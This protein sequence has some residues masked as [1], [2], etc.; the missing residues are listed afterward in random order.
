[1]EKPLFTGLLRIFQEDTKLRIILYSY[2]DSSSLS[3]S[4]DNLVQFGECPIEIKPKE[5]IL[6]FVDAVID[7]SRYF[8]IRLCGLF[9]LLILQLFRFL[10]D[11]IKDPES[12]RSVSIGIGFRE[13]ETAFDF[14]TTLNE[15]VRYVDRMALAEKLSELALAA[16]T[17]TE[18]VG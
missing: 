15:Y 11:R 14:K 8:V 5:D 7:S 2:K 1:L 16:T 4:E 12:S 10:S 9:I 3:T 17:A 18:E 6:A 13:R